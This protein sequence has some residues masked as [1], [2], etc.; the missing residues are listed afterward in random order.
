MCAIV[1]GCIAPHPPV[2]VPEIGGASVAEVSATT[3]AL[4][5]LRDRLAQAGPET[6][7]LVSPH[8]PYHRTSM[9]VLK[10]PSSS[11]SFDSWGAGGLKF[12]YE[13]DLELV[14]ALE[15]EAAAAGVPLAPIG[16]ESYR[17]D[18]GV[19]VPMHF[20]GSGLPEVAMVP[21]TYSLLPL[22]DHL[23]FGKAVGRAA[24]K[25]D[26]R[27]AFVASG[28]LSHR[29]IPGAPAGYDPAGRVF[30]ERLVELLRGGDTQGVL[31]LDPALVSRAGE[32]GL[33]S[34]IILLGALGDLPAQPEVLSYEGPFG[35][36]YLVASFKVNEKDRKAT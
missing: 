6:I 2:L 20:L 31:D 17:L 30:D 22:P 32:C 12:S 14:A 1:F 18:W 15:D 35:V 8:G 21:L 19:T 27:V 26:R 23:A 24:A 36:G 29:L 33:R 28:D 13:N 25:L 3:R 16:D 5:Q 10:Q 7:V 9:G 4:E 11:G 34:I